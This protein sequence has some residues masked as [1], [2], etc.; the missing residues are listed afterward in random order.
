MRRKTDSLPAVSLLRASC[1]EGHGIG[2][3]LRL[4]WISRTSTEGAK[5]V[6]CRK[7][8]GTGVG[9]PCSEYNENGKSGIWRVEASAANVDEV[10]ICRF[11]WILYHVLY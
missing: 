7:Q 8:A 6:W 10:G 3:V 4:S 2:R 9:R 5:V 11:E 1:F